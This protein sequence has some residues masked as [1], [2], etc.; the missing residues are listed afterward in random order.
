MDADEKL[1]MYQLISNGTPEESNVSA[2]SSINLCIPLEF[3]FC[4]R[5]THGRKREKPF[6]PLCAMT[7]STI[8]FRI[9]FNP[10]SWI[11]SSVSPIDII[12]PRLLIEEVTLGPEERAYY[13]NKT[14]TFKVP[15]VWK[16]SSQSYNN[17]IARLNFTANFPVSMMVWFVRNKRYEKADDKNF[18]ESRYSYGYTSKYI[19]STTPVTFF[20]GV[21]LRYI[22]TIDYATL[23]LNN[24]NVLSNFPGG[25]Y[26]TFKQAID[27]GL[28]VPTKNMYIYCFSEKPTEYNQGGALDFKDLNSD[29]SRL[30][31][32]FNAQYASQI[33]SE[34]S[35]NLFYYGYSTLQIRDGQCN[36]LT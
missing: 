6:F 36:L 18:F 8:S 35:L 4:H 28:S 5:Y 23:F 14:F 19:I 17:G 32:K 24:N 26:Y 15:R 11:T 12:N 7:L 25:L 1:G 22:D 27:H 3:F 34:F 9:T 16:E 21:S 10:Q 31:I 20:N 33:E 30:D 13:R 2:S 29:T